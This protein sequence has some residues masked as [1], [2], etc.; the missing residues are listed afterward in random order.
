MLS[1]I[2]NAIEIAVFPAGEEW[3]T[4]DEENGAFLPSETHDFNDEVMKTQEREFPKDY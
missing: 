3:V 2:E 4:L 1:R